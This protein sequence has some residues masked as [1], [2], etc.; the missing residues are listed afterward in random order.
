METLRQI[1]S[2]A[3]RI[4][5]GLIFVVSGLGKIPGWN[6]TAQYMASKG[7][8]LVPLFLVGAIVVEIVGG[9]SLWLGYKARWGALLLIVFLIPATLIFH[10]FWTLEGMDRQVQM[11]MFLKNLAIMGG[12]F[13]VIGLGPGGYSLDQRQKQQAG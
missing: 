3:G 2:F 8:P 1:A 11:I 9:L 6:E 12:L 5:L 10:N 7:M 13:L 4:L